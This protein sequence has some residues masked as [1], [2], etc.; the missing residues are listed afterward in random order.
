M[1][2]YMFYGGT[3]WGWI[4][5]PVTATSYDYNAPISEDRSIADKYYE[6]KNLALFTKVAE[7]LTMTNRI[8]NGTQYTGNAAITTVELRNPDSNAGFYILRHTNS[9]SDS[10]ETF[11]VKVSTS[12]GN[13]SIP[14]ILSSMSLSGHQSKIIVTDFRFG[15][16]SLAYSTAEVLTYSTFA[17]ETTL[18]LWVPDL[19][20]GEF[21]VK[22]AR[23]GSV[24]KGANANFHPE[25]GGLTVTFTSQE[26]MTVLE[27]DSNLRVLILDRTTSYPFFVPS[28]SVDP[29][30]DTSFN[31]LLPLKLCLKSH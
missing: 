6:T 24:L 31:G 19:E 15:S 11:N 20:S 3:N 21:F 28:L 16:F 5:A 10:F 13:F 22:N 17:N 23:T 25:S 26:G 14:R 7:D 12:I 30:A 18:V 1:S 2:L 27:I 4:A 8:N 29:L 9:S